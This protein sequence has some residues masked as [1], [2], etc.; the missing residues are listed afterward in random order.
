M[1]RAEVVAAAGLIERLAE[2]GGWD[3]L[4]IHRLGSD[5]WGVSFSAEC[6]KGSPERHGSG[7]PWV[8]TYRKDEVRIETG[9]SLA[10]ALLASLRMDEV[11]EAS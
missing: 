3:T 8:S 6:F 5:Q 4:T 11:T 9:P 2:S 10:A 1:T 7:L